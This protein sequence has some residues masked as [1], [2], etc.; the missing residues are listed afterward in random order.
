M[1]SCSWCSWPSPA[2]RGPLLPDWL[3]SASLAGLSPTAC[4]GSTSRLAVSM[5]STS[6]GPQA[7]LAG[8][9]QQRRRHAS[10]SMLARSSLAPQS[11]LPGS[12]CLGNAPGSARSTGSAGCARFFT[13]ARQG[14]LS[15]TH[16]RHDSA[17]LYAR[18][19]MSESPQTAIEPTMGPR[20]SD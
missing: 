11:P 2:D 10:S 17:Y 14:R 16:A 7:A 18:A 8:S 15:L 20:I 13:I 1:G 5:G 6:L 9:P 19:Q 3:N 12:G 4:T